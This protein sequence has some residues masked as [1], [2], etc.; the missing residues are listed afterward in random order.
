LVPAQIR[1]GTT[2][3]LWKERKMHPDRNYI[4]NKLNESLKL[5]RET[6]GKFPIGKFH[7]AQADAVALATILT[8]LDI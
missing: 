8:A 1:A 4:L 2:P 5:M 7:A 6:E 3:L